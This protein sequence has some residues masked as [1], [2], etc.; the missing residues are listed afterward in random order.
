MGMTRF[1][2]LRHFDANHSISNNLPLNATLS[3]SSTSRNPPRQQ[4]SSGQPRFATLFTVCIVPDC[5]AIFSNKHLFYDHLEHQHGILQFRCL[6]HYCCAS[7][8]DRTDLDLHI[9]R[10][11]RAVTL[12]GCPFDYCPEPPA[13]D[14]YTMHKHIYLW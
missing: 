9:Q 5:G 8:N 2:M 7:F 1:E 11:H 10:C 6:A 12:W 14:C 4:V 13:G 3:S